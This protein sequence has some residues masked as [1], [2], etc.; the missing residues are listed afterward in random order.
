MAGVDSPDFGRGGGGGRGILIY[1]KRAY[2]VW[3]LE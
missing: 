1:S 2:L 3:V